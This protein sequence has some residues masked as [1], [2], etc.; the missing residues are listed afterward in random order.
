MVAVGGYAFYGDTQLTTISVPSAASVGDQA[1]ANCT[2]LTY[3]NA[4]QVTTWGTDVFSGIVGQTIT[5]VVADAAQ[6]SVSSV[7]ELITNNTVTLQ[8]P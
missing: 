6:A 2:A 1:L 8:Y 7:A 4:A 3:L 5:L